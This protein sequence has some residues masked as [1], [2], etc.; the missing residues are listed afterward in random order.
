M[1]ALS[2]ESRPKDVCLAIADSIL[3]GRGRLNAAS[4]PVAGLAASG[5]AQRERVAALPDEQ[6]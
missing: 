6:G 2:W 5:L 3:L 1:R 4:E